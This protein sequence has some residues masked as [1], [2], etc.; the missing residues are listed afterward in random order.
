MTARD[1]ITERLKAL[2]KELTDH[3]SV[4]EIGIFG[5][6]AREEDRESDIDILVEFGPDADLLTYIGLWQFLEDR[7]DKRIDLIS[8]GSLRGGMRERVLKDLVLV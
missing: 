6:V 8:K 7:L 2:K 1:E 5:S 4:R 3:Y